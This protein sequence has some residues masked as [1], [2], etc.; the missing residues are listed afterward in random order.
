MSLTDTSRQDA[1]LRHL[2]EYVE[3]S[4]AI[5]ALVVVGS[6]A[7]EAADALSDLDLF[8]IT[9]QGR[10]EDAWDR[11]RDLH[12][13]GAIVEWDLDAQGM[14]SADIAGFPRSGARGSGHLR[15]GWW[16]STRRTVQARHRRSSTTQGISSA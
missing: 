1:L 9:Y 4:A 8:F 6:F 12:V 15:T 5:G 2:S 16:W 7:N 3:D 14:P 11:R 13:T 10:F